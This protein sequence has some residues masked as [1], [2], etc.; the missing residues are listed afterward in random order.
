MAE[1]AILD[2]YTLKAD[3]DLSAKQYHIVRQ[4]A[5]KSC[6]LASL[7]TDVT[8]AG[9]LQNKPQSGEHASVCDLGISKVV[10]GAVITQGK[11]V[12]CD[13]S[14]R[15]ITVTS[16]DMAVGRALEA[17]GAAGDIIGVRLYPPF[18]WSGAP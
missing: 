1:D 2:A 6:N 11:H 3:A 4:S 7:A 13:T 18:K 10:A 12:T 16:G 15:A 14:G 9:V 17:A 5:A 8:V